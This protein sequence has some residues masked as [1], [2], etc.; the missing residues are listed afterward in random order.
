MYLSFLVGSCLLISVINRLKGHKSIWRF[1]LNVFVFIVVFFWSIGFKHTIALIGLTV[2]PPVNNRS[3]DHPAGRHPAGAHV[4]NCIRD[5]KSSRCCRYICAIFFQLVLIC[6]PFWVIFGLFWVIF[7]P[8]LSANFLGQKIGWCY[9][10]RFCNS[11]HGIEI[12]EKDCF[13]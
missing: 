5:A 9:F 3:S 2:Q 4:I 10:L 12:D 6:G 7:G 11:G 8:F 1:S 13:Q